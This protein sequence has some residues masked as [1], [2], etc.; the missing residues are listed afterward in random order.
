M[1][2]FQKLHAQ[3]MTVILVTHEHDISR[4]ANRIITFRDGMII[5]DKPNLQPRNAAED[6]KNM[7]ELD[8]DQ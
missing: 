4:Y 2:L 3:G 1:V 8:L 6:L 5:S 7:P